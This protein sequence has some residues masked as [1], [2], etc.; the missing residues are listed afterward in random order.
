MMNKIYN[1]LHHV[2]TLVYVTD[3][4][5]YFYSISELGI[6]SDEWT[7]P[8]FTEPI[9]VSAKREALSLCHL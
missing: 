1:S 4:Q 5:V 9:E 7:L 3:P 6:F 2:Y 8:T